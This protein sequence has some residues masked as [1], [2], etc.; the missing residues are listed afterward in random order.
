MN[1]RSD[2][3]LSTVSA[4]F[5]ETVAKARAATHFAS[6]VDGDLA[7][8]ATKRAL[9]LVD[10]ER[11]QRVKLNIA[12]KSRSDVQVL[13]WNPSHA[14]RSWLLSAANTSCFVWDVLDPLAPLQVKNGE[15]F[16]I[17]F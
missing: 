3:Q 14:S 9:L 11:P 5:T 17:F 7:V 12:R 13:K 8:F 10:L 2:A 15:T 1:R 4:T 16:F 6:N